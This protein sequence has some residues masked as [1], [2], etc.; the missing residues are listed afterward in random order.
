MAWL[1]AVPVDR[2]PNAVHDA[3]SRA[4]RMAADGLQR[5]PFPP[6]RAG[7]YLAEYLT[8][9]GPVSAGGM[10]V[11]PLSY[12]EIDAWARTTAT[13]LQ[14]WEAQMLRRLSRAYA[15]SLRA[16]EDAGCLPPWAEPEAAD[17]AALSA[18]IGDALRARAK[19]RTTQ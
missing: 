15:A 19:P 2:R 7:E 12:S 5:L 9:A 1:A 3:R 10:G 14:P 17:R 11:A 4:E 16:S 6:V 18:R 13:P 8:D